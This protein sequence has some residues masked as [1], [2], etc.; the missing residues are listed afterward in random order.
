M[1]GMEN[2]DMYIAKGKYENTKKTKQQYSCPGSDLGLPTPSTCPMRGEGRK[3]GVRRDRDCLCT[4]RYHN[5]VLTQIPA[6]MTMRGTTQAVMSE[7]AARCPGGGQRRD[8][9]GEDDYT[10]KVRRDASMP[11]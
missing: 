9:D 7:D 1:V 11:R 5:A 6:S 10:S 3:D 4:T 8:D 2:A